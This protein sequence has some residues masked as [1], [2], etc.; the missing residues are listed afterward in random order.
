MVWLK[1][2]TQPVES[3]PDVLQ[4]RFLNNFANFIGKRLCWAPF[5]MKLQA[6]GPANL[7]TKRLQHRCFPVKFAKVLKTSFFT[8]Q[9][10][11]LLLNQARPTSNK[12]S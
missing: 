4:N 10:R 2:F 7:L 6:L 1:Q 3:F 11:W 9:L 12:D 5:L 8:E